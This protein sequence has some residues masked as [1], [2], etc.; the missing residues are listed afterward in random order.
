M[1]CDV[2][3]AL[4]RQFLRAHLHDA[5][6]RPLVGSLEHDG[7]LDEVVGVLAGRGKVT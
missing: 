4:T 2:L 1:D 3:D 7:L 5:A 6:F